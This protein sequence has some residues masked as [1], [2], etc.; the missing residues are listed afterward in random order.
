MPR[1]NTARLTIVGKPVGPPKLR[2]PRKYAKV[3]LEDSVEKDHEGVRADAGL[4]LGRSFRCSWG[5]NG[6]LVH[7]GKICAPNTTL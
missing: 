3:A 7:F 5:P 6:E 1:R 2:Q 4:A